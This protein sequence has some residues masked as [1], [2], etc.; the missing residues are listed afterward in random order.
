ME[1]KRDKVIKDNHVCCQGLKMGECSDLWSNGK[2][3]KMRKHWTF[4]AGGLQLMDAE[5]LLGEA[6]QVFSLG[7][8]TKTKEKRTVF[9]QLPAHWQVAETGGVTFLQ[10]HNCLNVDT[11]PRAKGNLSLTLAQLQEPVN[12]PLTYTNHLGTFLYL[13]PPRYMVAIILQIYGPLID[14]WRVSWPRLY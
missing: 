13:Y 9:L 1:S 8:R 14:I 6:I 2:R 11:S 5:D 3:C 7:W 12:S 4:S 10:E